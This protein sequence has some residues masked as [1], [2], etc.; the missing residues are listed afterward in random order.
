MAQTFQEVAGTEIIVV[1][2][3]VVA[4]DDNFVVASLDGGGATFLQNLEKMLPPSSL[5][6][7]DGL[8]QGTQTE[9]E[10]SA[11]LT[12]GQCYKN[13]WNFLNQGTLTEGEGDG[14]IQ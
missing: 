1:V 3:V 2:V 9:G 12:W 10:S 8:R 13:Q 14:S 6:L 7:T 11:K 5:P 4:V